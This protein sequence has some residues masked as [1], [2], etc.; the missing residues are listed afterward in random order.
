MANGE[1]L[2]WIG[3]GLTVW[4]RYDMV[5]ANGHVVV[6]QSFEIMAHEPALRAAALIGLSLDA[7]R[8]AYSTPHR[9]FNLRPG[10]PF[11]RSG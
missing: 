1:W 4:G 9:L 2:W 3:L 7:G 5:E 11:E 6:K 10:D 8:A